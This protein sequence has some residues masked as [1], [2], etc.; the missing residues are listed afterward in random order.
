MVNELLTLGPALHSAA[1]SL[2]GCAA[3]PGTALTRVQPEFVTR[4][5]VWPPAVRL[6]R[7]SAGRRGCACPWPARCAKRDTAFTRAVRGARTAHQPLA[8]TCATR[9]SRDASRA[10][11]RA[12]A[13]PPR[14]P[15]GRCRTR[16]CPSARGRRHR[17]RSARICQARGCTPTWI[18]VVFARSSGR[19]SSARS[20]GAQTGRLL[21]SASGSSFSPAACSRP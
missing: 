18:S 3:T 20:R 2:P 17:H 12:P 19:R 15:T 7:T 1:R 13:L 21:T 6:G 10:R 9:G 16:D 11:R 14:S 8:E 5:G 4:H